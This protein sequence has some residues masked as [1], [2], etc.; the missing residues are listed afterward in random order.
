[1]YSH[2]LFYLGAV[3]T[4]YA[5]LWAL[6][7]LNQDPREPPPVAGSVPFISPLLGLMTEKESY[8]VRMRQGTYFVIQRKKYGLP[9]YSLR[10]PGP[11]TYVVNSFRLVQLIDRHIREIAF[12]PIELRAIDK[13][14][15]VS[16]E[17]CEKV[18]GKDQ[19]LTENG[20]FRSFSRDVAA[21]ASPGPGLDALNRTAVE[22]IAASLDS[23]AAQG[24]TVVD[25]F[26]WV[27][28]EVFAATM[29]ATYGPHNPFRIPQNERD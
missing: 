23:L 15:G 29:E 8:Y 17:S 21:G 10:M 25:L 13:I 22:T 19:L 28:H 4:T 12:T 20:Y 6:A 24:E 2:I 5:L 9:I 18:S 7:Y 16:Q 3:G 26:D 1:M 11:T 14:M 27:R